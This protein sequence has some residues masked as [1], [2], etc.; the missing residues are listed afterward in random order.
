MCCGLKGHVL[1]FLDR[2]ESDLQWLIHGGVMAIDGSINQ[3]SVS[4]G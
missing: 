2:V 1:R 4:P 3:K